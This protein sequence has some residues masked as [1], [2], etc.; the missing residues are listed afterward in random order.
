MKK[1]NI[2]HF[3]LLVILSVSCTH[4]D[5]IT[6]GNNPHNYTLSNSQISSPNKDRHYIPKTP[7]NDIINFVQNELN[8]TQIWQSWVDNHSEEYGLLSW[9]HSII[10]ITSGDHYV[11]TVPLI[12]SHIV[13]GQLIFVHHPNHYHFNFFPSHYLDD[14]YINGSIEDIEGE[15]DLIY[16]LNKLNYFDRYLSDYKNFELSS[17]I[18]DYNDVH[19]DDI[20]FRNSWSTTEWHGYYVNEDG[21][22]GAATAGEI[23]IF[24]ECRFEEPS[25][26]WAYEEGTRPPRGGGP[27]G[28]RPPV[29]VEGEEE[30]EDEDTEE[31]C[32]VEILTIEALAVLENSDVLDPCDRRRDLIEE[33]KTFLC[34]QT[35]EGAVLGVET[36]TN[37]FNEFIDGELGVTK[38]KYGELEA[39][40]HCFKFILD[41]LG[42]GRNGFL[43]QMAQDLEEH[44]HVTIEFKIGDFEDMSTLY[45]DNLRT[46]TIEIPNGYCNNPPSVSDNQRVSEFIHELLHANYATLNVNSLGIGQDWEQAV[47][48]Y[49]GIPEGQTILAN[50][51]YL[52][53]V[54]LTDLIADSLWSLNGQNGNPEDY[55][56][57]V[58]TILNT[59]QMAEAIRGNVDS[60]GDGIPDFP[61]WIDELNSDQALELS[62]FQVENFR[63][64]WENNV[65]GDAAFKLNC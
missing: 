9:Q 18:L 25:S 24:I 4:E 33:Y 2:L 46:A 48:E 39:K 52:F 28:G 56:Y 23:S 13:T 57:Q 45:S 32:A 12:E 49:H 3:L 62:T 50:Q 60:N 8:N 7:D 15:G 64:E 19:Q 16:A 30:S 55:L 59:Q 65:G 41:K 1:T 22:P 34:S 44:E 63:D 37:G 53:F 36:V 21:T 51:H 26:E 10:D 29:I 42:R 43:C 17:F 54:Y 38:I 35:E 31:D 20:I 40:C 14:I 6:D 11:L 58:Y 61:T 27:G 47:R 5:A